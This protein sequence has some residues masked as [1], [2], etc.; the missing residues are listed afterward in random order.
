MGGDTSAPEDDEIVD[1]DALIVGGGVAGL[2]ILND[3]VAA[4][5][6][7]ALVER[8]RLGGEQTNHSHLYLHRGHVYTKAALSESLRD[9][10]KLWDEWLAAR[11]AD[12][13]PGSKPGERTYFGFALDA[14]ADEHTVSWDEAGIAYTEVEQPDWPEAIAP[15]RGRGR[16]VTRRL[17]ETSAVC[18][19]GEWLI[20]ELLRDVREDV[21]KIDDIET[22]EVN[23]HGSVASVRARLADDGGT[24]RFRPRMIVLAAGFGN[25]RLVD[26]LK[27][28]AKSAK[29]SKAVRPNATWMQTIRWAHMLVIRG[30]S[31]DLPPLT[32]IFD[33]S[34]LFIVSRH[35]SPDETVWIV[36]DDISPP[37]KTVFEM[38]ENDERVWFPDVWE[39]LQ[40]LA[41]S[42]FAKPERLR[43]GIY[44]A[45]K[46]E[47][48]IR[49]KRLPDGRMSDGRVPDGHVDDLGI[50]NVRAVWP[51]KLTLA[52]AVSR[53]VVEQVRT[54]LGPPKGFARSW[55]TRRDVEIA[56]ERWTTTGLLAWDDFKH[57]HL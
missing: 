43:W 30:P 31:R 39:N 47:V 53:R 38:L 37:P 14:T 34:R 35:V 4:G 56:R 19:T 44:S 13:R 10:A 52:P 21:G 46:A 26:L 7:A 12:E 15:G 9:A 5:Y 33:P 24:V 23:Q 57:R 40:R 36:S 2:F 11:P 8:T 28:S 54:E 45:P 50:P 48:T 51:T 27:A 17:Y 18:V 25:R 55:K 42:I 16:S 29:A 32:G 6:S 49:K 3:L 22:I 41:P 1:V 20:N